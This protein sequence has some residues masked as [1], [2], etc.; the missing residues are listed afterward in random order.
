MPAEVIKSVHL[1]GQQN[2]PGL[3]FCDRYTHPMVE[4]VERPSAIPA[5]SIDNTID[6]LPTNI[7][8]QAVQNFDAP[9]NT[10]RPEHIPIVGV[11]I[12]NPGVRFQDNPVIINNT[13]LHANDPADMHHQLSGVNRDSDDDNGRR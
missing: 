10:I 5:S 4:F 11:K 1:L 3:E 9:V 7:Q 13:G 2:P 6:H 8:Q 12:N